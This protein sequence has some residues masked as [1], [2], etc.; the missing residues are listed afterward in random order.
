MKRIDKIKTIVIDDESHWQL[1]LTKMVGKVPD[2]SLE[3][4]FSSVEEAEVFLT[5]NNIDLI[6]LDV[7]INESNGIEWL[8][9]LNRTHTVIIV[10]SFKEF[11]LEGYSISAVDYLTKPIDADK[12]GEAVDKAVAHV[13]AKDSF[14]TSVDTLSFDKDYFLIK[15]NLSTLK[16]EYSEVYAISALENYIKII[17]LKKTY[18]VLATLLQFERS[19]TNHPFL[20][21]HRSYIVNMNYIKALHK[22][23][24]TL[25]NALEIPLGDVYKDQIQEVFVEGKLIKRV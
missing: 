9:Q 18:V 23:T 14:A 22:D 16:I 24:L 11:A 17:T 5:Q 19:I 25:S 21:V 1:I 20:R 8:K 2:L 3:G 4:A 15:E 10:S 12:F 13:R 6:F 7:Q